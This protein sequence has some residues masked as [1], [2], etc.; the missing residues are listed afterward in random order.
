MIMLKLQKQK[1]AVTIIL[2]ILILSVFLTISLALSGLVAQQIKLSSQTGES[3]GAYEAADSGM[4]FALYNFNRNG[5]TTTAAF[6]SVVSE[7]SSQDNYCSG[8]NT[9]WFSVGADAY[10]CLDLIAPV[11]DQITGIKT[12]GRYKKVQRAIEL[13]IY[14]P[15]EYIYEAVAAWTFR[16]DPRCRE[17]NGVSENCDKNPN[18]YECGASFPAKFTEPPTCY[19]WSP[20]GWAKEY[21]KKVKP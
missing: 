14:T 3:A 15:P 5:A 13:A 17:Q 11:D 2:S 18:K 16:E 7:I 12:I 21:N 8:N 9:Y 1:G 20:G 4:E 19:D 6:F 10:F